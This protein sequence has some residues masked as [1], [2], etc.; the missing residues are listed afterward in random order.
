MSKI[1]VLYSWISHND[2]LGWPGMLHQNNRLVYSR[3]SKSIAKRSNKMP[4]KALLKQETFDEIHLLSNYPKWLSGM[5]I[6]W[7]GF[8]A[9][10]HTVTLDDPSDYEQILAATDSV[11]GKSDL[12]PNCEHSFFLTPGTPSMA[13]SWILV[14]KSRYD[15]VFW[16]SYQGKATQSVIV[17]S[18]FCTHRFGSQGLPNSRTCFLTRFC[19]RLQQFGSRRLPNPEPS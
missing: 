5:F 8:E 12:D 16:Q 17:S 7:L 19:R 4:I 18:H 2:L 9:N 15:A 6:E 14:G 1:R 13:A 3:H 10:V 11:L